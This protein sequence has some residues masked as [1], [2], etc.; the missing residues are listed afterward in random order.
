MAFFNKNEAFGLPKGTVRAVLALTLVG[1]LVAAILVYDVAAEGVTL[2]S[3]LAG[4][5][6][7]YYFGA[8]GAEKS[9]EGE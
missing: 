3:T 4:T 1:A 9:S 8:R 2:L 5:A 6:L 7:G